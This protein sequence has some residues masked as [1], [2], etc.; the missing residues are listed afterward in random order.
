L[1]TD[2]APVFAFEF[3]FPLEVFIEVGLITG[4]SS[5]GVCSSAFTKEEDDE[6]GAAGKGSTACVDMDA[7]TGACNGTDNVVVNA[8]G[9]GSMTDEDDETVAEIMLV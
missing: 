5:T 2:K 4:V 1:V 3:T 6:S 8:S 7:D 9:T